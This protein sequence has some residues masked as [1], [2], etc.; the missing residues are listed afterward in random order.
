VRHPL[1]GC[2]AKMK[3]AEEHLETLDAEVQR[4]LA[5]RPYR[6]SAE[7]DPEKGEN[8]VRVRVHAEPPLRLSA[9]VGIVSTPFAR[10]WIISLGSSRAS[11]APRRAKPSSPSSGTPAL[12]TGSLAAS[13]HE[14]AASTRPGASRQQNRH[15]SSSRSR[16]TERAIRRPIR[17]G[18]C[19]LSATSTSTASST[20]RAGRFK[21]PRSP[22]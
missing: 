9:I 12:T 4:F 18:S 15:S 7:L 22:C 17:C 11:T 5:G 19:T 3:R 6:T 1:D 14:V 13:R 8:L 2:V 20:S 10:A 21:A 16:T